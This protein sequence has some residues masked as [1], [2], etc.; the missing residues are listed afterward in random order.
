MAEATVRPPLP[1]QHP[2]RH[3][4]GG[5]GFY[6]LLSILVGLIVIAVIMFFVLYGL[7]GFFDRR[8]NRLQPPLTSVRQAPLQPLVA[9]LSGNPILPTKLSNVAVL[10]QRSAHKLTSTLVHG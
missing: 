9:C 8:D 2:E 5:L 1:E 3:E 4:S 7:Y 6:I 10:L